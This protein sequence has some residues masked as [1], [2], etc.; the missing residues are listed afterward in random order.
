MES[1]TQNLGSD[2]YIFTREC[3]KAALPQ[4][5][6]LTPFLA[7]QVTLGTSFEEKTIQ[8]AYAVGNAVL[9]FCHFATVAK[10]S[11]S[12]SHQ[13][14]HSILSVGITSM[15]IAENYHPSEQARLMLLLLCVVSF[16]LNTFQSISDIEKSH[17]FPS[18]INSNVSLEALAK[19]SIFIISFLIMGINL[20]QTIQ[21]IKE[22]RI[23]KDL[24]E[25]YQPQTDIRLRIKHIGKSCPNPN[26]KSIV[27]LYLLED[28]IKRLDYHPGTT[29]FPP[30]PQA[31]PMNMTVANWFYKC[32]LDKD[33]PVARAILDHHLGVSFAEFKSNLIASV[34]AFNQALDKLPPKDRHYV[35]KRDYRD[36]KSTAWVINIALPY[37]KIL[38]RQIV[39]DYDHLKVLPGVNNIVIMD[40]AAYSCTQLSGTVGIINGF[41]KYHLQASFNAWTIVPYKKSAD[42]ELHMGNPFERL[43]NVFSMP[44]V[45]PQTL[46]DL[47]PRTTVKNIIGQGNRDQTLYEYQSNGI[48]YMLLH[49]DH[50]IADRYSIFPSLYTTTL[51]PQ[52]SKN[53]HYCQALSQRKG[54]LIKVRIPPYKR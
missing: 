17:K 49:F 54:N 30:E 24:Q 5:A 37:L 28:K 22:L 4:I 15:A 46:W 9:A 42:C 50:K 11:K 41:A 23:T 45:R 32:H 48:E 8:K 20:L 18:K 40:D 14:G 53:N 31:N 43:S 6:S 36:E 34:Q 12:L 19:A 26:T 25:S 52:F 1:I 16:M 27:D 10:S 47:F 21:N 38:P 35:L 33:Q 2:A 51:P 13:L 7:L 29:V 39:S 3:T 44:S